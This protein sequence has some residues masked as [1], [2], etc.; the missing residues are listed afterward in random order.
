MDKQLESQL[1][2]DPDWVCPR[3]RFSNLAVRQ[4]CR[5]CGAVDEVL[6][7]ETRVYEV[8]FLEVA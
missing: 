5:N 3:C 2:Q 7:G 8:C 1:W 4:L 6:G